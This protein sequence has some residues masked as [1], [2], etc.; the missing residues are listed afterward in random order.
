M[1]V[2]VAVAVAV[3][4]S[5]TKEDSDSPGRQKLLGQ[6]PLEPPV[7]LAVLQDLVLGY[8]PV[9]AGVPALSPRNA[10]LT[11]G[12]AATVRAKVSGD[13]GFRTMNFVCCKR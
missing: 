2:A 5:V 10:R 8:V 1:A 11:S 3:V 4:T 6:R 12:Q 13:P 7:G 9:P